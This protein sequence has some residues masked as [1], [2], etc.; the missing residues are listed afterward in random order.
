MLL[1]CS[2]H[3]AGVFRA[4]FDHRSPCAPMQATHTSELDRRANLLAPQL[5][6]G[7]PSVILGIGLAGGVYPIVVAI[8]MIVFQ[9]LAIVWF[10]VTRI[11]GDG[12]VEDLTSLLVASMGVVMNA[13]SAALFGVVWASMVAAVML[14]LVY[15]FVLSLKLRGRI[16]WLGAFC[17]GL[18]GFTAVLPVM[19]LIPELAQSS[20]FW[21]V[22]IVLLGPGLATL[23]GQAGGAW[24][25]LRA[26]RSSRSC[27]LEVVLTPIAIEGENANA[28]SSDSSGDEEGSGRSPFQFGIRHLMWIA[29]WAS[30]LLTVIRLSGVP[31]ELALPLLIGWAVYQALAL[32]IG[33]RALPRL[34]SWQQA[35]RQRSLHVKQSTG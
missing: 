3:V 16:T 26:T 10:R 30:V 2:L 19:L 22:A 14:P 23:L 31:F 6:L 12:A 27:D 35:R 4:C 18:V 13:G 28:Y 25:G 9:L 1:K 32:A 34:Q 29:A 7:W 33:G 11:A 5:K 8:A 20:R 17:G 15:L 21:V 24:G